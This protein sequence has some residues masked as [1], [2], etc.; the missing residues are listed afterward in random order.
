[1]Q[2]LAASAADESTG[3]QLPTAGVSSPPTLPPFPL[4]VGHQTG[5]Y[6]PFSFAAAQPSLLA[7]DPGR[8]S[9]YLAYYVFC[10]D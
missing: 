1:M 2:H 8:V 5:H 10:K 6:H 3:I 7:T 9:N 4:M